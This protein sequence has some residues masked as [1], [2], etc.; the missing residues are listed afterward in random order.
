MKPAFSI[1]SA[2]RG[3]RAEVERERKRIVGT[4]AMVRKPL[5]IAAAVLALL[6]PTLA[7]ARE[8]GRDRGRGGERS[9]RY[10]RAAE[11]GNRRAERWDDRQDRRPQAAPRQRDRWDEGPPRRGLAPGQV[12]PPGRG[13]QVQDFNRYRLR[14]PPP[15]YDWVQV[16]RD[17]YLTQRSTGMVL[18]AIPGGF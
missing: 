11:R 2:T 15:G 17:I 5:V 8:Q 16:G 14:P 18:E 12:M 7:E 10:E 3:D 13:A 9:Q 4:E 1:G 6:G